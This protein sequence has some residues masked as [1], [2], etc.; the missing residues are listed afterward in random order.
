M[1]LWQTWKETSK[2]IFVGKM[3]RVDVGDNFLIGAF[4]RNFNLKEVT[5]P[6]IQRLGL[7][8]PTSLGHGFTPCRLPPLKH[9]QTL[10]AQNNT[11]QIQSEIYCRN[12]CT[13]A[14]LST[15]GLCVMCPVLNHRVRGSAHGTQF[16]HFQI[17]FFQLTDSKPW[18]QA[19]QPIISD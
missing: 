16:P 14:P 12:L 13:E 11:D 8:T 19:L 5:F 9:R 10:H 17:P 1:V 7:K 2:F 15:A 3:R 6:S 4:R 18:P